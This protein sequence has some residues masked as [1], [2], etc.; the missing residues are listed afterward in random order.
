L[1]QARVALDPVYRNTLRMTMDS[2]PPAALGGG[3]KS[4]IEGLT[5]RMTP[6]ATG[7]ISE[8]RHMLYQPLRI[9][10]GVAALVLLVTCVR[11]DARIAAAAGTR[12][13]EWR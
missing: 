4:F 7:G 6:A 8:F 9:L 10:W 3:V 13:H 1:D 11:R 2:L 12:S 5:F